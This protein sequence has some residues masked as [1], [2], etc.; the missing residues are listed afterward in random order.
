[1]ELRGRNGEE[2]VFSMLAGSEAA[3]SEKHLK[4]LRGKLKQ[5]MWLCRLFN[6]NVEIVYECRERGLQKVM[7]KVWLTTSKNILLKD[8]RSIPAASVRQVKVL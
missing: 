4:T 8:G 1:M 2:T 6:K 5:V 3:F 7:T